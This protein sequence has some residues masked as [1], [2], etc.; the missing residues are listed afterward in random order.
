MKTENKRR[1]AQRIAKI[2]T[3]KAK[4]SVGK[5]IP[6]GAHEVEVPAELKHMAENHEANQ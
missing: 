1:L 2:A 4:R 5:S 6:L 3:D